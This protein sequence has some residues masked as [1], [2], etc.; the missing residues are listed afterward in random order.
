VCVCVCVFVCVCVYRK[1][2][3]PMTNQGLEEPVFMYI[4]IYRLMCVCVCVCVFVC[5]YR[6]ATSPMTNQ[7]LEEP[8]LL[9]PNHA[10][11]SLICSFVEA[12]GGW[13]RYVD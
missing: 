2:T 6:K 7:G 13:G 3:S 11:R 1:A 5:V 10:L 9:I 12:R 4:Y 8:V